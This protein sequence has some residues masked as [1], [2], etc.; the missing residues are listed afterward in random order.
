MR[1]LGQARGRERDDLADDVA[2]RSGGVVLRQQQDRSGGRTR[3]PGVAVHQQMRLARLVAQGLARHLDQVAAKGEQQL[4]IAALGR[5]PSR[6]GLDHVV[7]IQ[8]E[9]PAEREI[10]QR[11]GFGPAG[12]EDRQDV[13]DPDRAMPGDLV[14]P[15]DRHP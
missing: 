13:G 14:K 12:I 1:R 9:P 10:A 8:L 5:D 2:R 3:H 6:L 15:A 4:D 7:E 11:L